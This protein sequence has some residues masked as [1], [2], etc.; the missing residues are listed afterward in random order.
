MEI[1]ERI[2]DP[3]SPFILLGKERRDSRAI[4][5]LEHIGTAEARRLLRELADGAPDAWR[6]QEAQAALRRLDARR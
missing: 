3:P 4:L 5:V 6:T 1:L 2:P